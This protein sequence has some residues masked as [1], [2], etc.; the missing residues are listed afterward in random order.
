MALGK[1]PKFNGQSLTWE[2]WQH[3]PAKQLLQGYLKRHL[4][5]DEYQE[6]IKRM[7][8]LVLN[9]T[10]DSVLSSTFGQR[11]ITHY[12]KLSKQEIDEM[13]KEFWLTFDSIV[14]PGEK[15]YKSNTE[16]E[17]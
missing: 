15:G 1:T 16:D 17:A 6:T 5:E 10:F 3:K 12:F 7:L 11:L 9:R 13:I 4:S 8:P 14:K 2:V